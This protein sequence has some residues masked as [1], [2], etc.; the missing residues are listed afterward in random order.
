MPRQ[1]KQQQKKK[2]KQVSVSAVLPK[3]VAPYEDQGF[4]HDDRINLL[5]D[6]LNGINGIIDLNLENY[7]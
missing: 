7:F 3:Y 4:R 1:K 5:Y 6:L 2:K